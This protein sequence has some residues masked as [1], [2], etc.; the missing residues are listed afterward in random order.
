MGM[1]SSNGRTDPFIEAIINKEQDKVMDNFIIPKME[2]LVKVFG[3]KV[4]L[5]D[6]VNMLNPK[7]KSINVFGSKAKLLD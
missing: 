2:V 7:V 3:K 6:K 1:D 5:M 4:Y